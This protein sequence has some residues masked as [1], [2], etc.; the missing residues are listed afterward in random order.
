MILTLNTS[1][2]ANVNARELTPL[3]EAIKLQRPQLIKYLA[4]NG[5]AID[6]KAYDLAEE[7]EE[8]MRGKYIKLLD[9]LITEV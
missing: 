3:Q 1:N 9:S 6:G 2:G 5:A 4:K 8:P 7:L